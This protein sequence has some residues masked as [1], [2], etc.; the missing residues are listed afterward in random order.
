MDIMDI[1]LRKKRSLPLEQD[2]D[3]TVVE[4]RRHHPVIIFIT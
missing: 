1:Y 3:C 2:T 4:G